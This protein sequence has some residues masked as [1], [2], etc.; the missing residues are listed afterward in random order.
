MEVN[1]LLGCITILLFT[2]R[3]VGAGGCHRFSK[4][5]G[6]FYLTVF[7]RRE[8]RFGHRIFFLHHMQRAPQVFLIFVIKLSPT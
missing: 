1:V 3:G 8:G 4:E 2:Q 7:E 5:R 6:L